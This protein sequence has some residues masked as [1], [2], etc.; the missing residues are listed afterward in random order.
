MILKDKNIIR[1]RKIFIDNDILYRKDYYKIRK[2]KLKTDNIVFN[3]KG[4]YIK[5]GSPKIN[6]EISS[7]K[8][9]LLKL[10]LLF[11]DYLEFLKKG[12]LLSGRTNFRTILSGNLSSNYSPHITAE[13]NVFNGAIINKKTKEKLS[14]ITLTGSYTNGKHN[15]SITSSIKIS[16][17]KASA[18]NSKFYGDFRIRN[19]IS[20]I[21][22]LKLSGSIMLEDLNRFISLDTIEYINGSINIEMESQGNISDISKIDKVDFLGLNKKC[23]LNISDVNFKLS[24]SKFDI[25]NINGEVLIQDEIKFKNLSFIIKENDFLVNG[26]FNNLFE[27]LFLKDSRLNFRAD[28]NSNSI[29]LENLLFED[30]VNTSKNQKPVI[31]SSKEVFFNSDFSIKNFV[32]KKFNATN[33]SGNINYQPE[34]ITVESFYLNSFNGTLKGNGAVLRQPD[35]FII[36]CQSD[37]E[38]I[39]IKELF[40]SFNNFGQDFIV[41]TNLNG[42]LSGEISFSTQWDKEYKLINES[43]NADCNINIQNGEL[44]EFTPLIG[45][46]KFIAVDELRHVKFKNLNNEILIKDKTIII[47]E[48]DIYSSALNISALGIHRF[49]NSYDYRITVSL[50]DILFKKARDNR[51]EI[52]NFVVIEDNGMGN[53][54]IP[55]RIIGK[56][57]KYKSSFDKKS[58]MYAIKQ[59]V[60][61][62]KEIVRNIIKEE[63][64][65]SDN[66]YKQKADS[67]SYKQENNLW[68]DQ[69]NKKDV[70]F[71]SRDTKDNNVPDFIIEWDNEEDS[72]IDNN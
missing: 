45:L 67:L 53:I 42:D 27:F 15:N 9:P 66:K 14:G 40:Y 33:I 2:G 20:P 24:G 3:I 4:D 11:P 35:N 68:E 29:N 7:N 44:I 46:S 69:N 60:N 43:V 61:Q 58:A 1:D 71:E 23:T 22:Y 56:N 41:D 19:L 65:V 32:F 59:K 37:L 34:I 12:F 8:A 54:S 70:I 47:P 26:I 52:D 5:D 36:H 28:I 64:S 62:E 50:S 13:F 49:D 25:E 38:S 6:L 51:K 17:F 18:R 10:L 21:V 16:D 57:E 31:F 63:F 55:L 30:Q 48:M 72:L 39:N